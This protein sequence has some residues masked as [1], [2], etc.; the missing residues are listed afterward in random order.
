MHRGARQTTGLIGV[1]HAYHDG[2][3]SLTDFDARIA[4]GA[5]TAIVGENG[6]GKST[7]L[8]LLLRL[9]RPVSG[10]IRI[11]GTPI[12]EFQLGGYREQIAYVPQELALFGGTIRDNIAFGR[13]GA[14]DDEVT[15]AAK[16]A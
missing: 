6:T 11:G 14:T 13:P 12:E 4:A 7:L 8:S 15:E 10:E 9:H 16:A 3:A 2:R 1:C 5:L